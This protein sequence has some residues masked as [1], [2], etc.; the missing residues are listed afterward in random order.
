MA[1]NKDINY[2]DELCLPHEPDFDQIGM[3]PDDN[4]DYKSEFF[5]PYDY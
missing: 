2:D 3:D 1:L 4:I 5:L